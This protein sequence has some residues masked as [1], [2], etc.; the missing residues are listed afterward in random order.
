[1]TG[2][3]AKPQPGL[4]IEKETLTGYI[5]KIS[6]RQFSATDKQHNNMDKE[7]L[8]EGAREAK[9]VTNSILPL[10]VGTRF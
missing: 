4:F 3:P 7:T 9:N 5:L 2:T 8:N 6:V 1:L 10:I